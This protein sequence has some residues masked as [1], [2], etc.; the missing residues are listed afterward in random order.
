MHYLKILSILPKTHRRRLSSHIRHELAEI[1]EIAYQEAKVEDSISQKL[2]AKTDTAVI[3]VNHPLWKTK[4]LLTQIF[5]IQIP[6]LISSFKLIFETLLF[7]KEP[8]LAHLSTEEEE[9]WQI[10]KEVLD[11]LEDLNID[12]AIA[13]TTPPDP[14]LK[15]IY[16]KNI[17]AYTDLKRELIAEDFTKAATFNIRSVNIFQWCSAVIP[18]IVHRPLNIIWD[19]PQK[20]EKLKRLRIVSTKLAVYDTNIDDIAD[21][22][23]DP[24]LTEWFCQIH[25]A[26]EEEFTQIRG[27][28]SHYKKG[29][30]LRFFDHTAALWKE[31]QTDLKALFEVDDF[32]KVSD[33]NAQFKTHMSN[34]MSV[35]RS[36]VEM[37][38]RKLLPPFLDMEEKLSSNMMVQLLFDFQIQLLQQSKAIPNTPE[39]NTEFQRFTKTIEK[40]FHHSN[41]FATF[42][43]EMM[44][45]DSTNPLFKLADT[46]FEAL[47]Q[48]WKARN[49]QGTFD[50]YLQAHF[51]IAE[52][53]AEAPPTTD[54]EIESFMDL[55]I[56]SNREEQF[57][58]MKEVEDWY[59]KNE[60][61]TESLLL[62]SSDYLDAQKKLLEVCKKT[63]FK[64]KSTKEIEEK[65]RQI[66]HF[67]T[68]NKVRIELV[69]IMMNEENI[70]KE[71][72][73]HW[74]KLNE[75]LNV[76]IEAIKKTLK[77]DDPSTPQL[78]KALERYKINVALFLIN[79]LIYSRIKGAV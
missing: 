23:Q 19:H 7:T 59:L 30:Y 68:K 34:L 9:S 60:L 48:E 73:I 67:L 1:L 5:K 11:P 71:Y 53:F 51:K 57:R 75:E 12:I 72:F 55:I 17:A 8:K 26:N 50:H 27:E 76:S 39:F 45:M 16:D 65:L 14:E 29:I 32:E 38:Q 44:E 54:L 70:L 43:R 2:A 56:P 52:P 36:S 62:T 15:Q 79:Y 4:S 78:E 35:M 31:I 6:E 3:T 41:C 61:I 21:N 40:M 37:N 77:T 24:K 49:P 69:N 74:Q 22:L 47:F 66:Q 64:A 25:T 28:I 18:F 58:M 46:K 42:K 10:I 13:M 20:E 33:F 63:E